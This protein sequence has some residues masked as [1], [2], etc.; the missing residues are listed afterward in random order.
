MTNSPVCGVSFEGCPHVSEYLVILDPR[1]SA[2]CCMC[3]SGEFI[4][5]TLLSDECV[6][7]GVGCH[8]GTSI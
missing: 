8:P 1:Y 6:W 7:D 5:V 2:H 4:Y 3:M